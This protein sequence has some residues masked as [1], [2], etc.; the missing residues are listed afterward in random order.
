[1]KSAQSGI[2]VR[3]RRQKGA[4]AME[5]TMTFVLFFGFIFLIMDLSM[6]VFIRGTLQTAVE[7]GVRAGITENLNGATYLTDAI[8]TAVQQNAKGFLTAH[9]AACTVQVQYYDPDATPPGYVTSLTSGDNTILIVSVNNYVYRPMGPI[10]QGPTPLS[11]SAVATGALQP[12]QN[13]VCPSVN[14]PV[15]PTCP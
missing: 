6:A 15:A 5:A 2:S 11:L 3:R 8:T 12:C 10:L 13:G 7:A 4:E 14:N 1:M 9:T